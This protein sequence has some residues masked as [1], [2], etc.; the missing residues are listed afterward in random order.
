MPHNVRYPGLPEFH[1]A[2]APSI[3]DMLQLQFLESEGAVSWV[4]A[5]YL[6]AYLLL[7]LRMEVYPTH[8]AF[9]LVEAY[10]VEAF[11]AC[12]RDCAYPMIWY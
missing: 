10:I 2:K 9:D 1:S 8:L 6:G 3:W 7:A 11:E 5:T 12:A 4:H